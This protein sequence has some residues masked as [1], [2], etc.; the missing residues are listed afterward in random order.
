MVALISLHLHRSRTG[1]FVHIHLL[2]NL[3]SILLFERPTPT[4]FSSA[5]ASVFILSLALQASAHALIAPMLGVNGIPVRNDVQRPSNAKPCG[6]VDIASTIDSSKMV[7]VGR[8]GTFTVNVTDF[9]GYV[10]HV[11]AMSIRSLPIVCHQWPR[12][13]ETCECQDRP[14][15]DR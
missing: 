14:H 4:M 9:N 7:H 8:N 1:A 10:L 3:S 2:C 13:L 11:L 15:W 5:L 12:W 6:N